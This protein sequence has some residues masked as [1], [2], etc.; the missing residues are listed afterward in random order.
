MTQEL[1]KTLWAT[2]AKYRSQKSQFFYQQ[3]GRGE[4]IY[5]KLNFHFLLQI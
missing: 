4:I 1:Q 3:A 5:L 2:Y